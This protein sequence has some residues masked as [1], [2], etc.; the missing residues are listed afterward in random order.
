MFYIVECIVEVFFH[1]MYLT[2]SC[3]ALILMHCQKHCDSGQ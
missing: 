2:G 3:V 1:T